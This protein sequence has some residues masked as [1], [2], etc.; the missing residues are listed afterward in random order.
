M[1]FKIGQKV[2]FID[3]EAHKEHPEFYPPVNSIGVVKQI[4]N[5]PPGVMT[6]WGA[7]SGVDMCGGE[8]A[9]WANLEQLEAVDDE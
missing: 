5:D 7:N 6:E 1:M 3:A 2:R 9:W 8:Y 4:A